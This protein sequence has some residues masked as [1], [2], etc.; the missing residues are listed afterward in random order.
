MYSIF[1]LTSL[2]ETQPPQVC[3]HT[4]IWH[5]FDA[6][7]TNNGQHVSSMV[8]LNIKHHLMLYNIYNTTSLEQTNAIRSG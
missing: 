6:Y 4:S 1:S 3:H 2:H 5:W 7:I 8:P